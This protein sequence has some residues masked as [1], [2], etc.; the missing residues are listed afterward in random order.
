MFPPAKDST[1]V[2]LREHSNWTMLRPEKVT[3]ADIAA[4]KGKYRI[5]RRKGTQKK[6]VPE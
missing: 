4:K 3:N 5:V 2:G 6:F 1:Q